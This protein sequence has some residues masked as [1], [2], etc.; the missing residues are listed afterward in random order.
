MEI[1]FLALYIHTMGKHFSDVADL[2]IRNLSQLPKD[3]YHSQQMN[4][5][6]GGVLCLQGVDLCC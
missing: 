3:H 1:G 6:V 5:I 2:F 4:K